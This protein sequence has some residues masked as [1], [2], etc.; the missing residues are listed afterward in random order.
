MKIRKI[1]L[2]MFTGLIIL[3]FAAPIQGQNYGEYKYKSRSGDSYKYRKADYRKYSSY[4]RYY[5]YGR[6]NHYKYYYKS[7]RK[8]LKEIRKNE[9]RKLKLERKIRK[10]SRRRHYKYY[11]YDYYTMHIRNLELEIRRLEHRNRYLR[12][13][14]YR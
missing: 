9:R 1:S 2:S 6:G 8:I 12:R 4:Q 14:L 7:K 13:L 3:C 10:Y 11:R 5:P